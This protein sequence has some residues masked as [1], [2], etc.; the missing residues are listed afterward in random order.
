MEAATIRNPLA[1]ASAIAL[2]VAGCG[3]LIG[4]VVRA[5]LAAHDRFVFQ[6]RAMWRSHTETVQAAFVDRRHHAIDALRRTANSKQPRR[7]AGIRQQVLA[8][9]GPTNWRCR[10]R[11]HLGCGAQ[12]SVIVA[13]S[14]AALRTESTVVLANDFQV[15]G[16]I[17]ALMVNVF[18][19]PHESYRNV[20][21]IMPLVVQFSEIG[22]PL[23][24]AIIS[25]GSHPVLTEN[26]SL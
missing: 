21:D 14:P 23:L 15:T 25:N 12:P 26:G 11:R 5:D 20:V 3:R 1:P 16:P 17:A 2:N 10:L 8:C 9:A 22:A 6:V 24:Y 7:L 18:W 4:R 19:L 13:H